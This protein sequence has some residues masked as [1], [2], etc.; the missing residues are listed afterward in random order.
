MDKLTFHTRHLDNMDVNTVTCTIARCTL[1]PGIFM[2]QNYIY[3]ALVY[4]TAIS[5]SVNTSHLKK[6]TTNFQKFSNLFA[7]DVIS[8]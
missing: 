1:L 8:S 7:G 3:F 2:F 6:N 4:I 5:A